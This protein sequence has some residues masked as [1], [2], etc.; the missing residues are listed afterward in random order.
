[1]DDEELLKYFTKEEL[2]EGAKE[3]EY[4]ESHLE[5]YESYENM[6]DLIKSLNDEE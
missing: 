1:M 4:M 6:D 3:L 5:E 2:E